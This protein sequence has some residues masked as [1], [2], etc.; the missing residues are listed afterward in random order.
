MVKT[1]FLYRANAITKT[2]AATTAEAIRE[3]PI[4]AIGDNIL[5]N[6]DKIWV[7]DRN[8]SW[9]EFTV[10]GDVS[11]TDTTIDIVST[12]MSIVIPSGSI[13]YMSDKENLKNTR[14]KY[15]T[16]HIHYY[17]ATGTNGKDFLSGANQP[18]NFNVNTNDDLTDGEL[19]PNNWSTRYGFFTAPAEVTVHSIIGRTSTDGGTGETMTFNFWHKTTDVDGTSTTAI[20]LISAINIT[21]GSSS[22]QVREIKAE[23]IGEVVPKGSVI[24]P[25]IQRGG[26]LAGGV[27]W[28]ADVEILISYNV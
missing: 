26:T 22:S 12:N 10:D 21:G 7:V 11:D 3:L 1:S 5:F 14:K 15:S 27:K 9:Y 23:N 4:E 17:Q 6:N 20:N 24:I 19:K 28:Y 16:I 25:T 2:T 13:I 8:G 18:F